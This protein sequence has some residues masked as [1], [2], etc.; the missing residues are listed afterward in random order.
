MFHLRLK[1]GYDLQY[2]A[3]PLN[4]LILKEILNPMAKLLLKS[5]IRNEET[6]KAV[7]EDEKIKVLP[8]HAENEPV[9]E[10]ED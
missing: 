3:R 6:V 2:G 9:A 5:Q 10:E 7:L 1:N 4:R 8:N